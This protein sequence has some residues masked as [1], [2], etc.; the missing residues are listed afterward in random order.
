MINDVSS[1]V[2]KDGRSEILFHAVCIT[3]NTLF[4]FNPNPQMAEEIFV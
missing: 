3:L 4:E 2:E 1:N